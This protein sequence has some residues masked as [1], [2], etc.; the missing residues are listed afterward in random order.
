VFRRY[1]LIHPNF[2]VDRFR[3]KPQ[4]GLIGLIKKKKRKTQYYFI[5]FCSAANDAETYYII[6]YYS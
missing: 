2:R 4:N 6:I 1:D 3:I 5:A